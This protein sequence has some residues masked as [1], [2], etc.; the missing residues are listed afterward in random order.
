[1][2]I[3]PI[4]D[5]I[6]FYSIFKLKKKF[7]HKNPNNLTI[8]WKLKKITIHYGGGFTVDENLFFSFRIITG[9]PFRRV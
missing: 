8:K 1:M 2:V 3:F 6:I 9:R 5:F 4:S 7:F